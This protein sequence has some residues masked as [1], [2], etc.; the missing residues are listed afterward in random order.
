MLE[1]VAETNGNTLD[2]NSFLEINKLENSRSL[3]LSLSF[4]FMLALA[5]ISIALKFP[6]N[7]RRLFILIILTN[8]AVTNQQLVSGRILQP[9]HFHWY[10]TWPM[11]FMMLAITINQFA[12][13]RRYVFLPWFISIIVC[14]LI[15]QMF[16]FIRG[17]SLVESESLGSSAHTTLKDL[18]GRYISFDPEISGVL[19]SRTKLLPYFDEN[20]GRMYR[21]SFQTFLRYTIFKSYF[22][23]FG[24][25]LLEDAL[26]L[27]NCDSSIDSKH[28]IELCY[29]WNVIFRVYAETF[30][31]ED[32]KEQLRADILKEARG[33]ERGDFRQFVSD[34]D[35]SFFFFNPVDRRR[36]KSLCGA[37][38]ILTIEN[39][40]LLYCELVQFKSPPSVE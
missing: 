32:W 11:L 20:F 19:V 7:I 14:S 5:L 23:G 37:S 31:A 40:V 4:L 35:I 16:A 38:T 27:N 26:L 24:T 21:N 9:G 17:S 39:S 18:R 33:F 1:S 15:I 28:V 6:T 25:R 34:Q 13:K 22:Y 12:S 8:F 29:S 2:L 10:F 3:S 36:A 30:G